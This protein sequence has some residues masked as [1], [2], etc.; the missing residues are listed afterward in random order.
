MQKLKTQ[1][2]NIDLDNEMT[3]EL[4]R[5]CNIESIELPPAPKPCYFPTWNEY[6]TKYKNLSDKD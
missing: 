5:R 1:Y 3:R 4:K 2:R 6:Q